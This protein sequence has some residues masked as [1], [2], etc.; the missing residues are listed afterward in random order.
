MARKTLHSL[1]PCVPLSCIIHLIGLV[2]RFPSLLVAFAVAETWLVASSVDL[3]V[4]R[5]SDVS[6]SIIFLCSSKNVRRFENL[7]DLSMVV[8]HTIFDHSFLMSLGSL[9][10]IILTELVVVISD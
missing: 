1:V 5:S 4:A 3:L 10:S 7:S 8:E 2:D 9:R 6:Y